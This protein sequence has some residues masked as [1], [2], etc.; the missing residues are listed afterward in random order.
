MN[1]S[2]TKISEKIV[3]I[4]ALCTTFSCSFED[5]SEIAETGTGGSLA[6]FTIINDHLY[7]VDVENLHIF[8]IASPASIVYHDFINVGFGIETIFPYQ[9]QLYIGANNGMYIYTLENPSNPEFA[10]F[11][12][13][14]ISYDPVV[15]QGHYAFVTLRSGNRNWWQPS[16]LQ[17]YDIKDIEN[18][19]L[20]NEYELEE[21]YGLAV[22]E[23]VLLVCDNGLKVFDISFINEILLL[24]KID[25]KATDV[26]I[27]DTLVVV[28]GE[29]GLYQYQANEDKSLTLLSHLSMGK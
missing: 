28:T 21:P 29:D 2:I 24:Q 5:L 14:M 10:S 13:H 11:S 25:V 15:V 6:R 27:K 23:D 7:T 19:R 9:N 4:F 22:K 16:S 17:I 12:N 3:V 18:P 26:I 1:K 20:I 8:D